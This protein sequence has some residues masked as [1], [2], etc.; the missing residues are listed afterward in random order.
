MQFTVH[1]T[2]I[3][4]DLFIFVLCAPY[5]NGML[6]YNFVIVI[7]VRRSNSVWGHKSKSVYKP[8]LSL[9]M[10]NLQDLSVS[11]LINA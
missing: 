3:V 9:S 4:I 5:F 11:T 2:L 1:S 7:V 8:D 6:N 10:P